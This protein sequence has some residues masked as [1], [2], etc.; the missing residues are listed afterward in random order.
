MKPNKNI[1]IFLSGLP[2]AGLKIPL[3]TLS[4]N[5]LIFDLL[6]EAET[7]DSFLGTLKEN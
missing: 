2:L 1:K 5:Q 4:V 7:P 3:L 6:R